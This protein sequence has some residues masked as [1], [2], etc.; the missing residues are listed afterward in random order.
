MNEEEDVLFDLKQSDSESD[1][2]LE[3]STFQE[4]TSQS[5]IEVTI[6]CPQDQQT[7]DIKLQ[8]DP[9]LKVADLKTRMQVLHPLKPEPKQQ[10]LL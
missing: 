7:N 2:P 4:T 8:I 6:V 9:Q 1:K 3:S 5:A 10:K